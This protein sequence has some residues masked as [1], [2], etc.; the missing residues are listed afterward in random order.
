LLPQSALRTPSPLPF[1]ELIDL[2]PV[3]AGTDS[4]LIAELT[5]PLF[6][7]DS[8]GPA[9]SPTSSPSHYTQYRPVTPSPA[10]R[11][12]KPEDLKL[13]IPL[14]SPVSS[15]KRVCFNFNLATDNHQLPPKL[16]IDE[17][18]G[19]VL[20]KELTSTI[21]VQLE[22]ELAQ[23]QLQHADSL[24]LKFPV[25]NFDL[26]KPPWKLA[27]SN[28]E[29]FRDIQSWGGLA[30]RKVHGL[31]SLQIEMEWCF[32]EAEHLQLP[33]ESMDGDE[34]AFLVSAADCEA[35]DKA[36]LNELQSFQRQDDGWDR[37]ILDEP[38]SRR[39][40]EDITVINDD[41]ETQIQNPRPQ[42]S[43]D[44]L[45]VED[46]IKNRKRKEAPKTENTPSED[47]FAI[48]TK[49]TKIPPQD[50]FCAINSLD[51][52]MTVRA[53]TINYT[54]EASKL[55]M[56]RENPGR[57]SAGKG[58]E[59]TP[60]P[61]SSHPEPAPTS[62]PR[63]G[64]NIVL[65]PGPRT[66]IVSTDLLSQRTLFRYVKSLYPSASFVERDFSTL[67]A[68]GNPAIFAPTT[69]RPSSDTPS[70]SIILSRPV[71]D[72]DLILSPK[73]GLIITTLQ[74]L[75]QRC[76]PGEMASFNSGSAVKDRL[77]HICGRYE[78]LILLIHNPQPSSSDRDV[79]ARFIGFTAALSCAVA[80]RVAD[81]N[82]EVLARWI[83]AAMA[84]EHGKYK[85]IEEETQWE[86]FLRVVGLNAFA[87]QAVIRQ[88]TLQGR[89]DM[90]GFLAMEAEEKVRLFARVVGGNVMGRVADVLGRRWEDLIYGSNITN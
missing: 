23:E 18:P 28:T 56:N 80:V 68:Y 42:R 53:R 87:A 73:C 60:L 11:L 85:L 33:K 88:F 76:L 62:I 25:L 40:P 81:G 45:S 75:R 70:S 54:T 6:V 58:L 30:A 65:T 51:A 20:L 19:E 72:A 36:L 2:E 38:V 77:L 26:Q 52:F 61:A 49:R 10:R 22:R 86:Q 35:A 14:T 16:K 43:N 39:E 74:K 84:A 32:F 46:L 66:F 67:I 1:P 37:D 7:R 41:Y 83:V 31:R 5:E 90:R 21:K 78:R 17:A 12:R 8:L 3:D 24:R 69:A 55:A 44:T 13:E 29:N 59:K 47:H 57:D 48:A 64:P 63:T 82:E 15:G 4:D 9:N 79:I 50:K 89:G 71:E 27:R 34:E